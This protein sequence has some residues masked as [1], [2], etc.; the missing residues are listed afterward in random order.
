M[1]PSL[2]PPVPLGAPRGLLLA[3]AL[4]RL[5]VAVC[6]SRSPGQ[7]GGQPEPSGLAQEQGGSSPGL[8]FGFYFSP[9]CTAAGN[10]PPALW[11]PVCVSADV[12]RGEAGRVPPSRDRAQEKLPPGKGLTSLLGGGGSAPAP[13][14]PAPSRLGYAARA[15]GA[16]GLSRC[17][18]GCPQRSLLHSSMV[19]SAAHALWGCPWPREGARGHRA[20]QRPVQGTGLSAGVG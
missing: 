3:L 9:E 17:R 6:L 4:F 8:L 16:A 20:A 13:G 14:I 11:E 2:A 10:R 7:G 15:A 19:G 12:T 18:T 1:G 5:A